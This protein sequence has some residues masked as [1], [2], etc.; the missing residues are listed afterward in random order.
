[1][2]LI[3]TQVVLIIT[4]RRFVSK[5]VSDSICDVQQTVIPCIAC[6]QIIFCGFRQGSKFDRI[7]ILRSNCAQYSNNREKTCDYRTKGNLFNVN[8]RRHHACFASVVDNTFRNKLVTN[9]DQDKLEEQSYKLNFWF[10]CLPGPDWEAIVRL[11]VLLIRVLKEKVQVVDI[12]EGLL[13]SV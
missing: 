1:M 4:I 5:Y 3:L 2:S 12:N 11:Y 7:P 10:S 8:K 9:Y 13:H 6:M